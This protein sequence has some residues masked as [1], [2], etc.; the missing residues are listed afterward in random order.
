MI[1]DRQEKAQTAGSC[2]Y[3]LR[4]AYVRETYRY[5]GKAL[6]DYPAADDYSYLNGNLMKSITG[7]ES[8]SDTGILIHFM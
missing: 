4:K 7:K 8:M 1:S 5:M 6:P 2:G 3:S